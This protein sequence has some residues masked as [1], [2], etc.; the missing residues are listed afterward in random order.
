[1]IVVKGPDGSRQE[2]DGKTGQALMWQLRPHK[3]G[4]VGLCNG[5][6]TRDTCHVYVAPE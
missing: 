4:I 2:Y 6:A 1:M 5:N 3:I